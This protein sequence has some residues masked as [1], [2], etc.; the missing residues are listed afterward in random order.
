MSHVLPMRGLRTLVNLASDQVW[1]A[2]A[3]AAGLIAAGELAELFLRLNAPAYI[4]LGM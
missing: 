4:P 3:V 1:F 2:L